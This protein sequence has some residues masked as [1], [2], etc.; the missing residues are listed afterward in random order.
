MPDPVDLLRA[1]LART[2][3]STEAYARDVLQRSP[4]VVRRWLAGTQALPPGLVARLE[5]EAQDDD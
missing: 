2:G 3:L 1:A 4:R 5:R